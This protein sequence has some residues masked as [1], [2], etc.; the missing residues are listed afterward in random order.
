MNYEMSKNVKF[1]YNE[2]EF[3]CNSNDVINV[4][5]CFNANGKFIAPMVVFP[6]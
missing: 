5:T 4:I 2:Q 1:T 6:S 3:V